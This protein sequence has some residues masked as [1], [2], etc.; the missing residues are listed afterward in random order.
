MHAL[1][2]NVSSGIAGCFPK[3]LCAINNPN[4]WITDRKVVREQSSYFLRTAEECPKHCWRASGYQSIDRVL[5]IFIAVQEKNSSSNRTKDSPWPRVKTHSAMSAAR[6]LTKT[7]KQKTKTII[8]QR[9]NKQSKPT[10]EQSNK[11]AHTHTTHSLS[12]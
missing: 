9:P 12:S 3:S 2:I 10:N 7:N 8:R 11:R 6:R 5:F 4:M 1:G